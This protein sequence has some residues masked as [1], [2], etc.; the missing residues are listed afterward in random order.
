MDY[1][2]NQTL[3]GVSESQLGIPGHIIHMSFR[4]QLP[5]GDVFPYRPSSIDVQQLVNLSLTSFHRHALTP[6]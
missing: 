4:T 3:K 5:I 1:P 6:E 2:C